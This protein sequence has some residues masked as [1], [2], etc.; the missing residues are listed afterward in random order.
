MSRTVSGCRLAGEEFRRAHHPIECQAITLSAV[1]E[2][3]HEF[4]T[5]LNFDDVDQ[6]LIDSGFK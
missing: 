5:R 1:S 6:P 2:M 3:A 4:D